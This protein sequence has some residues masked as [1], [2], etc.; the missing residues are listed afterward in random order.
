M[1]ER[2]WYSFL[3][4]EPPFPWLPLAAV[5]ATVLAV[6]GVVGCWFLVCGPYPEDI[7]DLFRD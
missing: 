3:G 6:E 2:K 4:I 7:F 1:R 5:V